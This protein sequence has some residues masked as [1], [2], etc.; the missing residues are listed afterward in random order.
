M[1]PVVNSALKNPCFCLKPADAQSRQVAKTS[2]MKRILV[3]IVVL[4]ISLPVIFKVVVWGGVYLQLKQAKQAFTPYGVIDWRGI[5]SSFDGK[6]GVEGLSVTPFQ[7]K[8]T[9]Q[10]DL[11][12]A[13]FKGLNLMVEAMVPVLSDVYP[14]SL[15]FNI[16]GARMALNDASLGIL[17]PD[18][19]RLTDISLSRIYACG[20]IKLLTGRELKAMGYESIEYD[21]MLAYH[22]DPVASKLAVTSQ[23]EAVGM[24]QAKADFLFSFG[25]SFSPVKLLGDAASLKKVSISLKDLGYY[26]RLAFLC[27]RLT[28]LSQSE[29]IQAALSEW[30]NTLAHSGIVIPSGFVSA[31]NEYMAL[32]AQL[33]IQIEPRQRILQ[34]I[35]DAKDSSGKL[36]RPDSIVAGLNPSFGLSWGQLQPLV[37]QFNEKRLTHALLTE[38]EIQEKVRKVKEALAAQPEIR[39]EYR[40]IDKSIAQLPEFVGRQV[41]LFLVDGKVHEGEMGAMTEEQVEIVEKLNSGSFAFPIR[42]EL[43]ERVQ[44]RKRIEI[45]VPVTPPVE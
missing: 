39:I 30:Q 13:D 7:L 43:V 34:L 6:I 26:R 19:K 35:Q 22:L 18:N 15:T 29:Y 31:L 1:I 38:G 9:L 8:E 24:G 3:F 23:I 5:Y 36:V 41:K 28:N 40:Y 20:D 33:D 37:I 12:E 45:K 4:A 25:G 10:I 17:Q 16:H 42:L 44:V 21:G 27:G 32:G 2:I 11:V 14:D